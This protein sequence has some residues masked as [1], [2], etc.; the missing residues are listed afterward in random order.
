MTIAG[1]QRQEPGKLIRITIANGDT[2]LLYA[3]SRDL[4]NFFVAAPDRDSLMDEIPAVIRTLYE[5]QGQKVLVYPV[6]EG[7][8]ENMPWVTIPAHMAA[9]ALRT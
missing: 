8:T 1:R 9:E 3:T 6:L 5:L 7:D 4:P 2:G